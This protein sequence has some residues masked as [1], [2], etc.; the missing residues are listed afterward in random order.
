[1]IPRA[2]IIVHYDPPPIPIRWFD[3]TA[4]LPSW[5]EPGDPEGLGATEDEAVADLM[6]Q[7]ETADM[8]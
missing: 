4:R 3:W 8:A 1:M 7:L 6:E 5:T 2:S